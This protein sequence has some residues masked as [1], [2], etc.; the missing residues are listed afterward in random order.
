M[1]NQV[2]LKEVLERVKEKL[3]NGLI[4]QDKWQKVN[5]CEG[6]GGGGG[7]GSGGNGIKEQGVW[8]WEQERERARERERAEKREGKKLER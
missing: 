3:K 6:E 5:E 7:K 1:D 4:E 2:E 8:S